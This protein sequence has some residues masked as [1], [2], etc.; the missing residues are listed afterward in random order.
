[1]KEVRLT[2][3]GIALIDDEDF[4]LLAGFRL[5]LLQQKT[6]RYV[7]FSCNKKVTLLHR[8]LLNAPKGIYVDHI[9]NDGLDNRRSNL[10]LCT[11]SQNQAWSWK[12]V[13]GTTSPFKGVSGSTNHW[14]AAII[15]QGKK[16]YIGSFRNQIDAALAYDEFAKSLFGEFAM[17][18]FPDHD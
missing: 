11:P 12:R 6:S 14:R 8:F 2:P 13:T 10:R 1:M 9:N 16:S 15:H 18:N 7:Q 17:V 5:R 4:E 3:S